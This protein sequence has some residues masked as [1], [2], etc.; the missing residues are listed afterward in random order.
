MG[1]GFCGRVTKGGLFAW[2]LHLESLEASPSTTNYYIY[3]LTQCKPH[4]EQV[5]EIR[6]VG[7]M[8]SKLIPN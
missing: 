7:Q 4:A 2:G 6:H 8:I 5:Q 3:I 1:I